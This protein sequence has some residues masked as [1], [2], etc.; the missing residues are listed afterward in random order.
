VASDGLARRASPA[1]ADD[2]L[3][4]VNDADWT[5]R[6]HAAWGMGRLGLPLLREPLLLLARDVEP[7][8][9]RTA[10]ASLG[11]L[12]RESSSDAG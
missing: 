10:R 5:V 2:L 1:E 11:K 4:L 7:V 6:N 12:A 9:A 3:A 8:V